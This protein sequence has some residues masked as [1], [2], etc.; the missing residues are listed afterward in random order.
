MRILFLFVLSALRAHKLHA[1]EAAISS[2]GDVIDIDSDASEQCVDL[3]S[4]KVSTCHTYQIA[5]LNASPRRCIHVESPP[6]PKE[7]DV[8]EICI[9]FPNW[10][11]GTNGCNSYTEHAHFCKE[12]GA[13]KY[14]ASPHR[15]N[16]ACCACGGGTKSKPRLRVG[17]SVVLKGDNSFAS[18]KDLTISS[19]ETEPVFQ[20]AVKI[21]KGCGM[22]QRFFNGGT[23]VERFQF[24]EGSVINVKTDDPDRIE[25]YYKVELRKCRQGVKA[26]EFIFE[27]GNADAS[28]VII[29]HKETKTPLVALLG[30]ANRFV[31]ITQ[32]WEDGL[33]D[34]SGDYFVS[35]FLL[36]F[37]IFYNTC[38]HNKYP[39][40]EPVHA[41]GDGS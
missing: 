40:N 2:D 3:L 13:F 20:Y 17:D 39:L 22:A 15:P 18:C 36:C 5:T 41:N 21:N 10:F 27:E 11:D 34:G 32:V 24:P 35:F 9:D 6:A 33:F 31:N 19:I 14:A 7:E 28:N 30:A 38:T 1:N 8:K 23:L 26:Q 4:G 37:I 16:E 12:F 29:S 25:K